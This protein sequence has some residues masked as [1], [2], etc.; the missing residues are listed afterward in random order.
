MSGL[1]LKELLIMKGTWKTYLFLLVFYAVFSFVGN[2]TFF[3][4]MVVV[5]LMMLPLSSV[6]ADEQARWDIYAATLPDGRRAVVRAKYQFAFLTLGAAFVIS[7]L[8]SLLVVLFDRASGNEYLDFV[9]TSLVSV[10]VGLLANLILYPLLFKY[11][12]QKARIMMGLVF[13]VVVAAVAIGIGILS[14][15]NSTFFDVVR[16]V[17]SVLSPMLTIAAVVVLLGLATVISYR[18]S[19]RIYRKKEF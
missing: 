1:L 10:A 6:A 2:P 12:S 8:V 4:S 7:C 15:S 13:G 5:I 9:V 11:G 16:M 18:I 17:S 14:F 3:A 19:Q